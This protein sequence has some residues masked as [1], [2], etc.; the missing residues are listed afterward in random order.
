MS[1]E[2][3]S[4]VRSSVYRAV[5]PPPPL[6]SLLLGPL[7]T[8]IYRLLSYFL[9]MIYDGD[10]SAYASVDCRVA[11]RVRGKRARARW[12]LQNINGYVGELLFARAAP[13]IIDYYY[14][15]AARRA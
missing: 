8:C 5:P 3:V 7:C 2:P 9:L 4:E 14:R 10:V 6:S 15:T 12:P 1:Y 11:C 13:R